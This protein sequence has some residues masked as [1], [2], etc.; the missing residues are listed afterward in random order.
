MELERLSGELLQGAKTNIFSSLALADKKL[1]H[2]Y[3]AIQLH[4][5]TPSLYILAAS[6]ELDHLAPSAAR[7]LMQRG[8]R[9]NKESVDLWR[10]YVKMELDFVEGLRRRWEVLGITEK[11][12]AKEVDADMDAESEEEISEDAR[13]KIMQ[14]EIVKSVMRSAV[15]GECNCDVGHSEF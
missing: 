3:R 10:E 12:K 4:P 11:G 5:T 15:T 1:L 14:G 9:M 13:A 8:I 6:H 2:T 7:S